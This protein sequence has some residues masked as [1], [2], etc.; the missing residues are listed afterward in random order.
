MSHSEFVHLHNHTEYSLLDGACRLTDDRGKPAELL[1]VIAR[2]FKM[3]ALAITDH[4]NMY[5]AMEFYGVCR[6]SGVKP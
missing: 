6:E 5:G 2:D 3:P 1:H 4:G